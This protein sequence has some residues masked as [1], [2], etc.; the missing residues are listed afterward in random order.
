LRRLDF[1]IRA[2]SFIDID[3]KILNN[4]SNNNSFNPLR[5]DLV[6][7]GSAHHHLR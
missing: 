3:D 6:V 1:V 2:G 4:N 7:A 5:L